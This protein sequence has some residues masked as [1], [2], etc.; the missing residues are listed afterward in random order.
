[1]PLP[2]VDSN[3][4]FAVPPEIFLAK[5]YP[6]ASLIAVDLSSPQPQRPIMDP[7]S[8]TA[9][10]ITL[11]GATG[12]TIKV[13]YNTLHAIV[14]APRE[15]RMQSKTL[16]SFCL[17]ITSL[18]Q[19]CETLPD[20]FP[21]HVNLCGIEEFINEAKK[22]ENRLKTKAARVQCSNIGKLHESCKW[23]LFDRQLEKFFNSLEHWNI[24]LSQALWVVQITFSKQILGHTS[25]LVATKP[26]TAPGFAP[27]AQVAA[28]PLN[29]PNPVLP[30]A[31]LLRTSPARKRLPIS[32][33]NFS[34]PV[35]ILSNHRYWLNFPFSSLAVR[36]GRVITKRWSSSGHEI[37]T[38]LSQLKGY[39]CSFVLLLHLF[40]HWSLTLN[41]SGYQIPT[42]TSSLNIRFTIQLR[43]V[44]PLTS[45]CVSA[46]ERGDVL[47]LQQQLSSGDLKLSDCAPGG[48]SLLHFAAYQ[49]QPSV[50]TMLLN[51]GLDV[52]VRNDRGEIPLHL[53]CQRGG[54]YECARRLLDN[55][56][57][58]FLQDVEG[59]SP[60]HH[61]YNGVIEQILLRYR[62]EIDPWMQD[63][64]GRTL[65]HWAA[66]SR[67]SS[68]QILP[69]LHQDHGE[70]TC[71]DIKDAEG[72]SMLHYAV[73]RGNLDL[74]TFL[75]NNPNA[76][77]LAMPDFSG[78]TLLHY[79]TES[80]RTETITYLLNK[81]F[82]LNSVD[83][84][85]RTVLHHAAKR[86]NLAASQHLIA[87]STID[88]LAYEDHYG[89]TS[90]QL[91]QRYNSYSIIEYFESLGQVSDWNE[92]RALASA[93]MYPISRQLVQ[94]IVKFLL[95]PLLGSIVYLCINTQHLAF[96]HIIW[97]RSG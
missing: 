64:R 28:P 57:D 70:S 14:G 44:F 96:G 12:G 16:E 2:L 73:R 18:T 88:Q 21:L 67:R 65:L 92:E 33:E 75:F 32:L 68:H 90:L 37:H 87:L 78:R 54:S 60:L 82:S 4:W 27:A 51:A 89:L 52:N 26:P 85:G 7:V 41:L 95:V 55:G 8:T 3:V 59:R 62:D 79:A 23:L 91:A 76:S 53:I 48:Y 71:L 69:S 38:T 35:G 30:N 22:M 20:N 17:T 24:I 25:S 74:V 6:S 5:T 36:G 66:W 83:N 56:A 43:R 86:G 11:L 61:F 42:S 93:K 49:N 9:S 15:I 97:R 72:K 34:E 1:M 50:V 47:F 81:G 29:I 80:G 84:D 39:S 45:S 31:A 94:R 46:V 58:L 63:G 19:V 77:T 40:S 13:L 10:I